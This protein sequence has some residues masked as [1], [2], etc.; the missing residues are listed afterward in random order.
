MPTKYH[1]ILVST[2]HSVP[3]FQNA[4]F[5]HILTSTCCMPIKLW[6]TIHVV[7]KKYRL[8]ESVFAIPL[9]FLTLFDAIGDTIQ[10]N[11]RVKA[12]SQR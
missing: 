2:I 5:L 3:N 6:V 1:E 10:K 12:A 7:F 11:G 9:H 8:D 4:A